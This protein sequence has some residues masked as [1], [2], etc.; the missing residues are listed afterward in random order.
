MPPIILYQPDNPDNM[1]AILRI[2]ACYGAALHIIEPCGFIL[3]ARRLRRKALDYG[4]EVA[5]HMH[6]SWDVFMAQLP[7]QSRLVLATTKGASPLY[8]VTFSPNDW[9][10][11]GRE[12][13][14]VPEHV[15]Q[16]VQVRCFIPMPGRG[17]SLNLAVS[18]AIMLSHWHAA[19]GGGDAH[20]V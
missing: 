18:T 8:S 15:H 20:I 1:G 12:S 14:G 4:A 9:L 6:S 10:L 2:C 17:R 13:A 5:M 3:D 11:F 7:A 16:A 19:C